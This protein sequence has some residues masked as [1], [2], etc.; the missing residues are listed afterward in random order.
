MIILLSQQSEKGLSEIRACTNSL[1][2]M[3]NQFLQ[4]KNHLAPFASFIFSE[5][6]IHSS[7]ASGKSKPTK[8]M[9][10]ASEFTIMCRLYITYF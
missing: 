8:I 6:L 2:Q 3:Y 9:N 1:F 4:H 10:S 5:D 7:F